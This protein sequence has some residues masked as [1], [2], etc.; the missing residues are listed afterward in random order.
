MITGTSV[1]AIEEFKREMNNQFDMSD[2]GKLTY[3]LGIEVEQGKDYIELKQSAY[4]RKVLEK[5]GLLDCNPTKYPF[6]PKEQITKDEGGKQ[7]NVTQYKSLIG[8]LRYLVHTKPDISYAV[9]IVSRFME[10]PT[11]MHLNA[12][13]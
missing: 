9:G 4:A 8:G 5:A 2:L 13:K 11:T 7:V 12:I 3:Y 6:D 10:C 1:A